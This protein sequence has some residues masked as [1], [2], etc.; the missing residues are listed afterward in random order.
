[1]NGKIC[2]D[3]WFE[4][5]EEHLESLLVAGVAWVSD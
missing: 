2:S 1:M 5:S 4:S 3:N